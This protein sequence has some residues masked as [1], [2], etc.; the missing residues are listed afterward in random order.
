MGCTSFSAAYLAITGLSADFYRNILGQGFAGGWAED[1]ADL[2]GEALQGE[3]LL[4]ESLLAVGGGCAGEGVLGVAR[5]V[6]DFKGGT[7]G[8][9]LLD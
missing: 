9:E 4:Q 8:L 1:F 5:E 3:R 2:A 7:R 6:E